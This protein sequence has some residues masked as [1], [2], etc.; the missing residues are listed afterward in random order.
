MRDPRPSSAALDFIASRRFVAC[1]ALL[2]FVGALWTFSARVPA[3]S[4]DAQ[5]PSPREGFPAPDFT[6][7]DFDG[8]PVTL[9]SLRGQVVILNVWA[10]WCGPCRA[11]MPALQRVYD[12]NRARGLV[13]LGVN[14][15]VQDT[16]NAARDFARAMN[17]TFPLALDYDGAVTTR[18]RVQAL[19]TTF[20]LDRRGVI[21]SVIVGGPLSEAALLSK[22]QTLLDEP[23]P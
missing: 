10:S 16:A 14:S 4:G 6:L 18:Y 1:A 13:T 8:A 21:R 11:E 9:H 19:P 23:A 12:A 3:A 2:L 5:I 15:T 7:T 20:I 22:I 17:V